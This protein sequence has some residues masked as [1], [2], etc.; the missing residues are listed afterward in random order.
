MFIFSV[1]NK[2]DDPNSKVVETTDAQKFAEQMGI[3]LFETSAK[4]NINVEEVTVLLC[5]AS[6]C[7]CG[8]VSGTCLVCGADQ[9]K[10]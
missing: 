1:G 6:D 10:V 2:N 7:L 4:E 9:L 3:N 8:D 5:L